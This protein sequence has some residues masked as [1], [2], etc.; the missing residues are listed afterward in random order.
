M[1]NDTKN[2]IDKRKKTN[3]S[4]VLN[5]IMA[6]YITEGEEKEIQQNKYK[7]VFNQI[8]IK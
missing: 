6:K 3:K 5:K 4:A 1:F 7:K 2:I 8:R